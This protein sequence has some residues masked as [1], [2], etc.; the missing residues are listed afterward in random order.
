MFVLDGW[1]WLLVEWK[2]LNERVS[3]VWS[4]KQS[5][6]DLAKNIDITPVFSPLG[7]GVIKGFNW[8]KTSRVIQGESHLYHKIFEI[9]WWNGN[10]KSVG[11]VET[12]NNFN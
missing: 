11:G 1:A 8:P 9:K 2:V 12:D 7:Y 5:V 4:C 3:K 10:N 6:Q